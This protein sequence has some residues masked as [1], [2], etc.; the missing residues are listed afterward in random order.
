MDFDT[1]MLGPGSSPAPTHVANFM[2]FVGFGFGTAHIRSNLLLTRR[3]IPAWKRLVGR[4]LAL[5]EQK[6][7]SLITDFFSDP[8]EIEVVGVL[9]GDDV[10][11]FVDII[12][13][14]LP[15][16]RLGKIGLPN[17]TPPFFV[18]RVDVG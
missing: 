16:H 7:I 3:G 10:Q 12:D 2:Q 9:R 6:H 13:E 8:D 1:T 14:V 15:R 5:D 17:E 18:R 4:A 11:L